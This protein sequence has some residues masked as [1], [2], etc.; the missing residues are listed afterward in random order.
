MAETKEEVL[1]DVQQA[2]SKTERYLEENKRSLAIIFGALVALV[3]GYFAWQRFYVAPQEAE[4]RAA[5]FMAEKYFEKDSLKLAINGDGN[6]KGF[7]YIVEEYGITKAANLA[8]Y[9]LGICYLR[10]GKFNEAIAE[11]KEFETNDEILGPMATGAI[12][13]A[14]MELN[15][16]KEAVDYYLKAAKMENNRFTAPIFLMKAAT[17]YEE[18]KSFDD[19]I[20]VYEQLRSDYYET[21]EGKDAERYIARAKALAG[22]N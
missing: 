16:I 19:A 9:Y 2:Y 22:K 15:K 1:V 20:R 10:Q 11:M 4:A 13:D 3:G 12:G 5:M 18:L 21:Q 17:G 6:H 8:H 7:K 14:H